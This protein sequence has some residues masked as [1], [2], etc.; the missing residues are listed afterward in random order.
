MGKNIAYMLT[1]AMMSIFA[2][3]GV[4]FLGISIGMNFNIS[5]HYRYLMN[6]GLNFLPYNLIAGALGG[7]IGGDSDGN[8]G[9]IIGGIIAGVLAA[10]IRLIFV[11]FA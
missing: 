8:N 11:Y 5:L 4:L 2:Y 7:Y 9:A 6:L 1:G 10:I 3:A